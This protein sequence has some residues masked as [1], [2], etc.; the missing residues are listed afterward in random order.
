[1]PSRPSKPRK[2][3]DFNQA[4]F[5]VVREATEK[6][7]PDAKKKNPAAVALGRLGASKGGK[8]RAAKL[9]AKRR[10]QIARKAAQ[11]R[12]RKKG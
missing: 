1:M 2:E 10:A 5:R 6:H 3:E 12:W 8:A 11:K 4:A 7:D 9:S